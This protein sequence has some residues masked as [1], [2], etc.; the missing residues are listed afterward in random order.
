MGKELAVEA[1]WEGNYRCRV[2]LTTGELIIDEPVSAGG[3]GE[4]PPPNEVFLASLASCFAL[5]MHHVARK[6][7]LTLPDLSVRAIGEYDGPK[8][9]RLGVEVTSSLPP[10]ELEPLVAR[11]AAMCYVSNTLR[12][13]SG[14][15]VVITTVR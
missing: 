13:V 1:T 12:A 5:A 14:V 10:A 3:G 2:Q 15:E 9:A 6:R 11:A 4:G 8:F 7:D